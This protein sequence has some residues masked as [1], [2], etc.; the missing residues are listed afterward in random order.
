MSSLKTIVSIIC[1]SMILHG[2][3]CMLVPEGSMKKSYIYAVSVSLIASIVISL[4]GLSFDLS[5][6]FSYD[7]QSD[8]NAEIVYN[9]VINIENEVAK[10][11]ILKLVT[12]TVGEKAKHEFSA[13]VLTDISSDNS[14]SIKGILISCHDD[15]RG[16]IS[17]AVVSLGL[18]PLFKESDVS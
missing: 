15:D 11:S 6:V 1:T 2:I 14:I 12:E 9:E 16:V 5:D 10:Q 7:E 13:E 18:K 8:F 17:S 4:G 3:L